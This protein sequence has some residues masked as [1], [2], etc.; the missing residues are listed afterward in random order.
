LIWDSDASQCA[1]HKAGLQPYPLAQVGVELLLAHERGPGL[2]QLLLSRRTRFGFCGK[3]SGGVPIGSSALRLFRRRAAAVLQRL[4]LAQ[5]PSRLRARRAQRVLRAR[6]LALPA[7][8][9]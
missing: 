7:V 8:P 9:G 1:T 2:A 4:Q 6:Q 5:P 3:R